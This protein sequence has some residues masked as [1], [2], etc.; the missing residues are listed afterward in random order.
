MSE[1][2]GKYLDIPALIERNATLRYQQRALAL[3][4]YGHH[5]PVSVFIEV[6]VDGAIALQRLEMDESG[7]EWPCEE[8]L[9]RDFIASHFAEVVS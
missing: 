4:S 3:D 8:A 7:H 2:H 5:I 6:A 1:F 9:L